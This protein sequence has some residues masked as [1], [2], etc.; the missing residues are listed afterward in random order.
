M[1]RTT[2]GVL[3]SDKV[4]KGPSRG[5]SADASL[6]SKRESFEGGARV[7]LV[8]G[9]DDIRE[10]WTLGLTQFGFCVRSFASPR[11]ALA[12]ITRA[13][14]RAVVTSIVL[15][16]MGGDDLARAVRAA[17]LAECPALLAA[18][19]I[20]DA[21]RREEVGL[22]DRVLIKPI[23]LDRLAAELRAVLGRPARG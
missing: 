23:D 10:L 15:P 19:S 5:A 13:P 12:D 14:P 6:A 9:N 17:R 2:L 7:V 21:I 18:T 20:P 16:E 4:A 8:E 11:D 1:P 22:F 3:T